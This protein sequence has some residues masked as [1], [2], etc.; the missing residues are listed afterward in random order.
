MTRLGRRALLASAAL[1]G[2]IIRRPGLRAQTRRPLLQPGKQTLF[3]RVVARPGATL[4]AGPNATPP[5]TLVPGFSTF[6]V[7]GRQ[8]GDAGWVEVGPA[9]DGRSAGWIA[10]AKLIDWPHAMIGAFTNP[11]GRQPVLFLQTHDAEQSLITGPDPGG[12][13]SRLKQ[14]ALDHQPGPV[15]AIE[16][17]W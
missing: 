13:A 2:L 4:Q 9:A 15:I 7:Y 17:G 8:G 5:G 12:Q 10:A 6:Y 3:Q 14:A 11:A 16:P 1:A